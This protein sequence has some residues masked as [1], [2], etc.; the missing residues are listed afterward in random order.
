[1]PTAVV[2]WAVVL[3]SARQR[4]VS[5]RTN[6][7]VYRRTISPY[8]RHPHLSPLQF[9]DLATDP[10]EFHN[11][12]GQLSPEGKAAFERLDRISRE[13]LAEKGKGGSE[14]LETEEHLEALKALG[15]VQ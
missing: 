3:E 4:E 2:H 8:P 12:S 1:M 11:L 5:V 13:F 10:G 6:R 9:Y 7:W 14:I 15:Y